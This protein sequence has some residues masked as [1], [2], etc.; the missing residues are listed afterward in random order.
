MSEESISHTTWSTCLFRLLVL[1]AAAL[2]LVVLSPKPARADG[3]L[4]DATG[5]VSDTVDPVASD[6]SEAVDQVLS[7]TTAT[8]APVVT[9]STDTVEE[10]VATS[11]GSLDDVVSSTTGTVDQLV[12][13]T[14]GTVDQVLTTLEE[15]AG[16]P[17]DAG[18]PEH[19]PPAGPA[20]SVPVPTGST[21]P[22]PAH[23]HEPVVVHHPPAT[24]H[25]RGAMATSHGR[26]GAEAML[27]PAIARSTFAPS[28]HRPSVPQG[29]TGGATIPGGGGGAPDQGGRG[30]ELAATLVAA[31][32]LAVA[33]SRWLRQLA[34]ARAPNP[35]FSILAPPG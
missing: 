18:S 13:S 15:V 23:H 33:S 14:N 22:P 4:Q 20:P 21:P 2:V 9:S 30:G 29:G 26:N 12:S 28:S 3:L 19:A 25:H 7:S 31:L 34:V 8:I 6:A 16:G 11:V 27:Q 5:T 17:G 32:V 10:V 35:F 24:V 1:L